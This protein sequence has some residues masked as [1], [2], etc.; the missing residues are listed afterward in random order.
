MNN[1]IEAYDRSQEPAVF[2]K[3]LSDL[4]LKQN[5]PA[6]L[7]ALYWFYYYTAKWQKTNQ[8]KATNGYVA[9]GLHWSAQR[10]IVIGKQLQQLGLIEKRKYRNPETK[11]IEGHYVYIKFIWGKQEIRKAILKESDSMEILNTNSLSSN[12]LNSLSSDNKR[13]LQKKESFD[14]FDLP[15]KLSKSRKVSRAWEEFIQHR[16][17]IGHK[18]TPLAYKK[19][20]QEML[21][22]DKESIVIEINYAIAQGWRKPFFKAG[23]KTAPSSSSKK[24]HFKNSEEAKGL[25]DIIER[26][27]GKE[28]V[29]YA[30]QFIRQIVSEM[31]DYYTNLPDTIT[32]HLDWH[33]FFF[34]WLA[35]LDDKQHNKFQL[36]NIN[37]LNLKRTRWNEYISRLENELGL[38]FPL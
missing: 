36:Q 23:F 25:S 8:P 29:L 32:Y 4:I 22:Q 15:I 11:K 33:T 30:E 13:I 27:L 20:I 35:Y 17:E 21:E 12:K 7:I 34:K 6:D 28:N 19:I 37:Q 16:K 24:I 26:Y 5:K 1:Q 10:V 31:K 2:S 18:L 38:K 3:S 14:P 9:K